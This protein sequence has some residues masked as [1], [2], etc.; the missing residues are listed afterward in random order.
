MAK[1][2]KP[3]DDEG[4]EN[5]PFKGALKKGAPIDP[6]SMSSSSQGSKFKSSTAFDPNSI[7][8]SSKTS[9]PMARKE[10]RWTWTSKSKTPRGYNLAETNSYYDWLL[11]N[12]WL[13]SWHEDA[14][15]RGF[16]AA[17][18]CNTGI[19]LSTKSMKGLIKD[20]VVKD[21]IK[22]IDNSCI[23]LQILLADLFRYHHMEKINDNDLSLYINNIIDFL[24][25]HRL[26]KEKWNK[27]YN[28][29]VK[30][31]EGIYDYDA[32]VWTDVKML[33]N[34]VGARLTVG[35]WDLLQKEG[36]EVFNDKH[37]RDN[38][39]DDKENH[40]S[41]STSNP[42]SSTAT[43]VSNPSSSSTATAASI[44]SSSTATAASNP[45]SS[46]TATAAS[47]PSSSSTATAA[48]NPS[49]WTAASHPSSWT[50]P[51]PSL[52]A[53]SSTAASNPTAPF[54]HGASLTTAP[55]SGLSLT[56]AASDQ[57][58][59]FIFG[60][61][62]TTIAS[63]D[64]SLVAAASSNPSAKTASN[65]DPVTAPPPA[66]S[67]PSF[68]PT[69]VGALKPPPP[70]A[71]AAA[72]SLF[73]PAA[74]SSMASHGLFAS[75]PP[76]G[77]P[78]FGS[79]PPAQPPVP[80]FGSQSHAAQPPV[81]LFGSL[82]SRSPL[83]QLGSMPPTPPMSHGG[84]YKSTPV[85]SAADD[86][87]KSPYPRGL[88]TKAVLKK[89]KDGSEL[90]H[91]EVA[92][93]SNIEER[94]QAAA[95]AVKEATGMYNNTFAAEGAR[96][97]AHEANLLERKSQLERA[98]SEYR[99][100]MEMEADAERRQRDEE[101]AEKKRQ[102]DEEQAEKKRQRDKQDRAEE[103]QRQLELLE[104][105]ASIHK[106]VAMPNQNHYDNRA[107]PNITMMDAV[108]SSHVSSPQRMQNISN[109]TAP[110]QAANSNGVGSMAQEAPTVPAAAASVNHG[111]RSMMAQEAP[112]VPAAASANHGGR[113]MVQEAPTVQA[114][115]AASGNGVG[116]KVWNF[117]GLQ[118]EKS[119]EGREGICYTSDINR[120]NKYNLVGRSVHFP[121]DDA[122][123][124]NF[125]DYIMKKPCDCKNKD[126]A[127][128]GAFKKKHGNSGKIIG[129]KSMHVLEYQCKEVSCPLSSLKTAPVVRFCNCD[130]DEIKH[131]ETVDF[132]KATYPAGAEVWD[133]HVQKGNA[134]SIVA[135]QVEDYYA[136]SADAAKK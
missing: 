73:S 106:P 31:V 29:F 81:S 66:T 1:K 49:S 97:R 87:E 129:Y 122:T 18:V 118:P 9:P 70:Q 78:Q 47:N 90:L 101:Q 16:T 26:V 63:N 91:H 121:S 43:A 42:S 124:R 111:G 113:L 28:V 135:L 107:D 120:M 62:S 105:Q 89:C 57:S 112:T 14:R 133:I 23:L 33:A 108:A 127:F 19:L 46:S 98:D 8:F 72:Q 104:L 114:D 136:V 25:N 76:Y 83:A 116:S 39:N 132:I 123:L 59:P 6:H 35:D 75:Q 85:K 32:L 119:R 64:P 17:N 80:L 15:Q 40:I 37:C 125:C 45:S 65:H 126:G 96:N 67:G 54:G 69:P 71:Q 7:E 60:G 51:A 21:I 128:T 82:G 95:S 10:K 24:Q 84:L 61:A 94:N 117:T 44:P 50:A 11:R 20:D 68:S 53:P 109:W 4:E 22:P 92:G 110:V 12:G 130:F 88:Y 103:H 36:S 100:R 58:K 134:T 38:V 5:P 48:S 115:A 102:R 3:N 131:K 34:T 30:V 74:P 2:R 86:I 77:Q 99:L 93:A 13:R 52:T 79:T 55:T 56:A 41:A 27:P